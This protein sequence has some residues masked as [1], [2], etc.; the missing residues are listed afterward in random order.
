[1]NNNHSLF[2]AQKFAM[3]QTLVKKNIKQEE[4]CFSFFALQHSK[5]Y[6]WKMEM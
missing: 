3:K 6:E 4:I 1:L 2:L 5:I